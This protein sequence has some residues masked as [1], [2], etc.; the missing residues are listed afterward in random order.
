VP[1]QQSYPP[2]VALSCKGL[3]AIIISEVPNTP[4][5]P[6]DLMYYHWECADVN[7]DKH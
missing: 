2:P 7:V 3:H 1:N 5:T 4:V 6:E